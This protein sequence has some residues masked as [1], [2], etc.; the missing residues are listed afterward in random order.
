MDNIGINQERKKKTPFFKSK[1]FLIILVLLVIGIGVGSYLVIEHNKEQKEK[2]VAEKEEEYLS[3]LKETTDKI[4]DMN[5]S[6]KKITSIYAE[7]WNVSIENDLYLSGL[8]KY[9]GVEESLLLANAPSDKIISG[10]RGHYI[11]KGDFNTALITVKTVLISE[12]VFDK[13]EG[14]RVLIVE[15]L[16]SLNNPPDKYKDIYEGVLNYFATYEMHLDLAVSP[17]GSYLTYAKNINDLSTQL[18]SQYSTLQ[19]SI[20]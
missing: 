15:N 13:V 2:E 19:V 3:I 11:E 10:R 5:Q 6:L 9:L 14:N 4:N 12:G 18:E 16:K 1:S 8:S 17:T 7:V 20:P